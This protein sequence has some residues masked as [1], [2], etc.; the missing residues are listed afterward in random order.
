MYLSRILNQTALSFG[1]INHFRVFRRRSLW[2]LHAGILPCFLGNG[3]NL[4]ARHRG[5]VVFSELFH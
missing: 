5:A 1:H 2:N 4:E 3:S